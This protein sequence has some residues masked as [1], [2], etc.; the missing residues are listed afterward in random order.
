MQPP[1]PPPAEGI[2]PNSIVAHGTA[3]LLRH[4]L[5]RFGLR[6][7]GLHPQV[8]SLVRSTRTFEYAVAFQT[9]TWMFG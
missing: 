3:P 4:F 8:G 2:H 7:Q 6:V 1:P 5:R 9:D